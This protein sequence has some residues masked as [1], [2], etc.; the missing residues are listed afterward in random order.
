M[1]RDSFDVRR[2]IFLV[3]VFGVDHHRQTV[4]TIL[5]IIVGTYL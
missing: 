1:D 4:S 5:E 2:E 3:C